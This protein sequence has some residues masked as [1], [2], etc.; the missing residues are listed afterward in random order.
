MSTI[1][2]NDAS[3]PVAAAFAMPAIEACERPARREIAFID[4]AV[5]QVDVL[6]NGMREGVEAIVLRA[7]RPALEQM[8][9]HLEGERGIAAVHVFA[10][11]RPGEIAFSQG[12]LTEASIDANRTTLTRLGD[13]LSEGSIALWSCRAGEGARGEG[14]VNALAQATGA[15]VHASDRVIGSAN[16]GGSWVLFDPEFKSP[17]SDEAVNNYQGILATIDLNG[18]AS[19]VNVTVNYTENA[20]AVFIAPSATLTF[21]VSTRTN[22]DVLTV[23]GLQAG[24]LVSISSGSV[25]IGASSYTVSASGGTV[26]VVS[27]STTYTATYLGGSAS[28]FIITFTGNSGGGNP[29]NW[30]QDAISALIER[31][32]Y[33]S[34]SNNPTSHAL[35]F[36]YEDGFGPST[37][38]ANLSITAVND[39]PTLTTTSTLAYTENGSAT[40]I[41][42]ALTVAD[43]DNTT[44]TS[45]TVSITGGFASGQDVLGFTNVPA[46]MGNI[47]GTYNASTGVLTLTSSGGTAAL[48]QWQTALRAVTY[49]NSSDN[50]NTSA[51]GQLCRQ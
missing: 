5:D 22:N 13:A 24:D 10:H 4:P 8:A 45:A 6:V 21:S 34:S 40:A 38:L 19:N 50:P 37:A 23:S 9:V 16:L 3:T 26:T 35:T 18:S 33:S 41:N 39:A 46:T 2:A 11:G 49:F 29:P 47:A 15:S 44:L 30:P 51:D 28:D 7:D 32:T 14:L 12:A 36:S 20:S 31:I 17:L 48:A 1:N 25:T 43:P 27:G 42:T